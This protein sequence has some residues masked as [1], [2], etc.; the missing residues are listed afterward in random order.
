[1]LKLEARMI[2]TYIAIM[3]MSCCISAVAAQGKGSTELSAWYVD[4][5][6]KVF[7]DDA[8]GVHALR[9]PE[10]IGARN[11]HL[12]VQLAIRSSHPLPGITADV[13][14]LEGGAGRS[15]SSV[16]VHH[17]GYVV[18][19]SHPPDSP[20]DE[21]VGTAPGW[22]PDPLEDF[23]FDLE[24]R[25]TTPV[26]VTISIPADA[27]PGVYVGSIL[28]RSGERLVARR[29]FRLRVVSASVPAEMSLK[30]TNWF[31]LDDKTSQQFFGVAAYSPQW[32]TLVSNVAHVLAAHRQNVI[33]TPLLTLIQPRLEDGNLHYDFTNFDRWV[34]TFQQAGAIGYIEGSHLLDRA[35]SYDASLV[36]STYQVVDGKPQKVSLPPDDPRVEPAVSAFLAALGAH[37]KEK[38]WDTRYFQHVLDEAHGNEPPYYARFAALIHQ[39]MPGIPTIDAIDAEN[40]PEEL[41]KNCDIWVPQ[42]GRFDDQMAMLKQR[43]GNDHPVWFYTCLYPQKRYLNRLMDLP[44]I[45]VR[46][47]Q[48]LDFRYGFTGFLHWGGNYWTPKPLLDTQLVIDDNTEL[49]PSGDAF[50]VYPD[51]Q[52]LAVRSSIRFE[53]MRESIEDY[54]MLRALASRDRDEADRI[55]ASAVSSFTDYVRDPAAFRRIEMRLLEALNKE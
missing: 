27:A 11:Q 7:P 1:M 37:L 13:K 15:I 4:S 52:H 25:R 51:R 33:I 6:V 45:K 23:P 28:L 46:L 10:F 30:V 5:L 2:R 18:V 48:W 44:L 49:L 41:Q 36:A 16:D 31:T 38:G 14:P 17:V 35:G 9:S 21:L 34:E 3:A 20:P 29:P 50:V 19:G 40:L 39:Q 42:L 22:Y 32:W 55:C 54:E 12:S 53:A 8:S 26:W 47:L 43:I 24:A